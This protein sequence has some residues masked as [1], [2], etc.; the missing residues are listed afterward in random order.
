MLNDRRADH[1][2]YL[3]SPDT[4]QHKEDRERGAYFLKTEIPD[5]VQDSD[6][7]SQTGTAEESDE[8]AG[9]GESGEILGAAA[10][11]GKEEGKG[12]SDVEDNSTTIHL[13]SCGPKQGPYADTVG[14]E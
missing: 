13:A 10:C 14:V 9:D 4:Q 1:G 11:D 5:V 6:A 12:D 3:R 7:D 8:H 2:R